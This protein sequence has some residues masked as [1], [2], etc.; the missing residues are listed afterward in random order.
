MATPQKCHKIKLS[1]DRERL[2]SYIFTYTSESNME[3]NETFQRFGKSFQE[4][5]CH[6]ILQDRP[7]CD[8]ITEVLDLE[9]LQYEYLRIFT[10]I[11]LDG[12][13][14]ILQELITLRYLITL[15]CWD[16]CWWGFL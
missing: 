5:L 1:V 15:D 6:L 10:K 12:Q 7:F 2:I 16:H 8:Q 13:I 4:D 11:I 14:L 3:Q 9:F